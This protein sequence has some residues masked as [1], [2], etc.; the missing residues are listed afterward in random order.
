MIEKDFKIKWSTDQCLR[1]KFENDWF[2]KTADNFIVNAQNLIENAWKFA[3]K[4]NETKISTMILS[5]QIY[6]FQFY[7]FL[8]SKS[9]KKRQIKRQISVSIERDSFESKSE[10]KWLVDWYTE[11]TY[12]KKFRK[13]TLNNQTVRIR[14]SDQ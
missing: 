14:F 2:E 9:N 8:S 4:N 1:K 5:L 13:C 10:N 6:Y 12:K 3:I 7:N 11:Y